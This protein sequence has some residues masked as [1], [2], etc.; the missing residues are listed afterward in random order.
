MRFL[1]SPNLFGL[2]VVASCVSASVENQG[3]QRRVANSTCLTFGID[4]Q[5]GGSY[6]INQNSTE[7]FTAVSQFE[8][9]NEA[10]ADVWFVPPSGDE[11]TCSELLT[12]PSDTNV[13]TTCPIAKNQLS[14]GNYSM[15]IFGDNADG[16]PFAYER[17]FQLSV[18]PQETVTVTPTVTFNITSFPHTTVTSTSTQLVTSTVNATTTYSEPAFTANVT[19]TVRPRPTTTTVT[20]TITWNR[21]RYTHTASLIYSTVTAS[22][23]VPPRPAYPDPTMTYHPRN[24]MPPAM[25]NNYQKKSERVPRIF[26]RAPDAPTI[27]VSASPVLN[28]TSTVY[29]STVTDTASAIESQTIY[30]TLAPPTIK[31]GTDTISVTTTLP[32]P[33]RTKLI[34]TYTT[35]V[36]TITDAHTYTF[37]RTTTPYAV[38]TD[39]R[40]AGGHFGNGWRL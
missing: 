25:K 13:V 39:C 38:K 27:T 5:D 28:V 8:G 7:Q 11:I 1:R 4:F 31:A 35:D 15:L 6:F 22:C 37:T 29:G 32:T 3:L 17:D 20:K 26:K 18:G 10:Y 34:F 19:Q 30:T 23:T 2:A 36:T 40:E 16:F 9:C 21:N 14:T 24:F 12:T 33:I